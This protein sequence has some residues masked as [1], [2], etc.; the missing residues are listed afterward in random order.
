[1]E[2]GE[3]HT[4]RESQPQTLTHTHSL[5]FSLTHMPCF[6]TKTQ[7]N[8]DSAGPNRQRNSARIS[9][10]LPPP[11]SQHH[12]QESKEGR[13][14][15]VWSFT[16]NSNTNDR[17]HNSQHVAETGEPSTTTTTTTTTTAAA[18]ARR[19]GLITQR[20][21]LSDAQSHSNGPERAEK[22]SVAAR[23]PSCQKKKRK[24]QTE[25]ISAAAKP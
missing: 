13:G 15:R 7:Q 24:G 25:R 19:Q 1:M 20:Q 23:K 6:S 5:S 18:T 16:R 14:K 8:W 11:H 17:D 21:G 22:L 9:K 12:D 10:C 3:T 4:Q 2:S